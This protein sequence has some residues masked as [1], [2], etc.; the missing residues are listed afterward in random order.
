MPLIT[1]LKRRNVFKVTAAYAVVG[2]LVAQIAEFATSTFGAPPW[3]LRTF[4]LLLLLGLPIAITLAWAFNL[5]PEGVRRAADMDSASRT[6][7][8]TNWIAIA[9]LAV[10]LAAAVV[11]QFWA[12]A[13]QVIPSPGRTDSSPEASSMH[14]DVAFPEDAPLAF[15]GAAALG[16]GR[17][18]FSLSPDGQR[19]VFLGIEDGEYALYV[20]EFSSREVRKLG[21]TENGYDPFFSPNGRWIGFFAGNE[22]KRVATDGG[23][24]LTMTEATNSAGGTWLGND[25]IL[26]LTDEGSKL[27][28]Y[29]IDGT[30]EEWTPPAG[31]VAPHALPGSSV[32][33]WS[34]FRGNIVKYDTRTRN[35]DELPLI[36][37]DPRYSGGFLFYNQGSTLYAARFDPET[38]TLQ[39]TP[40]PILTGLRAEV[41]GFSQWSLAANGRFLYAPGQSA[42]ENPLVWVRDG[43]R[44][45]LDLPRWYKGSFEISP[46]GSRLAVLE[47]RPDGSDIWLHD[48]AGT[49]PHKL[50]IGKGFASNPLVW[51]PNGKELIFHRMTETDRTPFR[52]SL[53][54]AEPE[55]PLLDV[56]G[57]RVSVSSVSQDG[58]FLGAMTS[59]KDP[60][61]EDGTGPIESI[62]IFDLQ[63]GEEIEIPIAGTG[64][65]GATISPDRRAIVYTSPVSGQYQNYL[66]PVPP[67]GARYQVSRIGGAEEPR[68]SRDGRKIYY[69]SGQRIMVVDVQTEP[70]ITLSEP[71]EFYA[72]DFVNVGGRSFDISLDGTSALLIAAST[73]TARSIRMI[74]HW[75]DR[76]E[77]IVSESERR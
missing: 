56:R 50:S 44:R 67:T 73:G 16:N 42:E 43:E 30:R 23:E 12:P 31:G 70:E 66:Q 29:S 72:G 53:N 75:L 40:V 58:R 22:L 63:E 64:N 28:L 71:R 65:W 55:T 74:T 2:W 54:S 5:T 52:I 57:R 45:E 47:Y 1:E 21:G 61:S 19:M 49:V 76:V 20:R 32:V 17:R 27:L 8:G 77:K 26:A 48:F 60:A 9:L 38:G 10:V 11:L 15:V 41:Y 51:L 3:V 39:G 25:A 34:G 33:L 37:S 59:F 35:L 62:V 46:D 4:V 69:R 14:V 7:R 24:A 36:G 6:R 18:A 68:W 13:M